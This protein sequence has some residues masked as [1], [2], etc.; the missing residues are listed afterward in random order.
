MT[1]SALRWRLGF[2]SDQRNA[3]SISAVEHSVEKMLL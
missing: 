3:S 2:S 1:I